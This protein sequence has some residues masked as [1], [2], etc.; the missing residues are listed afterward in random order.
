MQPQNTNW[1]ASHRARERRRMKPWARSWVPT[2]PGSAARLA[3]LRRRK[4][5]QP[6]RL[7][8]AVGG[9]RTHTA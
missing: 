6:R 8:I 7:S 4:A 5:S 3:P 2:S 1:W 9:R